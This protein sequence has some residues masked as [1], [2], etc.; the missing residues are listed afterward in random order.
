MDILTL[1]NEILF[2]LALYFLLWNGYFLFFNKG[3]PNIKTAPAIR[4]H[5]LELLKADIAIKNKS[6]YRIIDLG[7]GNGALSRQI[8]KAFP[9]AHII[10]IEIS[11]P[12]FLHAQFIQK[13]HKLENLTYIR[14][15]FMNYN[16]ANTDAILIYLTIYQM[17]ALGEKL[18]NETSPNTLITSNQFPLGAGWEPIEVSHIKT[19]A[20]NQDMLYIYRS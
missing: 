7:C 9:Q 3:V 17:E 12:S 11:L 20:I 4:N 2:W 6:T 14:T 15:N 8:A 5:I 16:L 18:K 10:G 19:F 13:I 1:I